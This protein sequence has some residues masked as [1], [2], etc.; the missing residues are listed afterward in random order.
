MRT[1]GQEEVACEVAEVLDTPGEGGVLETLSPRRVVASPP[2]ML[3]APL[4]W[5]SFVNFYLCLIQPESGKNAY[6]L[7][8]FC[9]I[10]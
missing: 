10:H 3:L 1:S 5:L 7:M 2:T 4:A 8:V 6:V 9:K